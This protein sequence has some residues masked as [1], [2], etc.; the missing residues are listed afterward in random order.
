MCFALLKGSPMKGHVEKLFP[1]NSVE[2]PEEKLT[3][4]VDENGVEYEMRM[5]GLKYAEKTEETTAEVGDTVYCTS[6]AFADNRTV[7]VYTSAAI[8]G[9]EEVSAALCGKSM[10][11]CVETELCGKRVALTVSKI[12]RRTPAPLT[13]ALA[14][15]A[16]IDGVSTVEEYR[17]HVREKLLSDVKLE[18][19]KELCR[20]VLDELI[21]KSVFSYDE[22]EMDEYVAGLVERYSAEN[23]AMGIEMT[24]EE[25][26]CAVI[27][28]QKQEWLAQA[29]CAEKGVEVDLD[30]ARGEAEQM[31]EQM[32][33]MMSLM[34]E[35][36]PDADE[37]FE[38]A[39]RGQY[40]NVLFNAVEEFVAARMGN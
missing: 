28:N 27:G 14:K 36:V 2:I 22:K 21:E 18:A 7:I 4:T 32:A 15:S 38:E 25:L 17:E 12:V 16:G 9:T 34:G 37:L 5:L 13:D 6:D 33:E 30:E 31:A 19:S 29:I 8:P 35:D 23:A 39:V 11:D 20:F 26:R 1:M 10:G 40:L 3:F 24:D